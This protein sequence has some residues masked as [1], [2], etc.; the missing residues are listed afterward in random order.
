LQEA[1]EP[2]DFREIWPRVFPVGSCPPELMRALV[3]DIVDGDERFIWE[4]SVH[5][6]LAEWRAAD[7]D[8]ADVAF[9]VVD[10]ETTGSTP[11]FGKITEIGAVRVQNGVV[12][13][14]FSQLVDPL[15]PIPRIITG[16][17]GISDR[18]VAGKPTID[19]V[20]PRFVEFSRDSVMVAHNARFDMGFLDYELGMLCRQSFQRPVLD[21]M[22][23]ARR[24][25]PQLRS[26]LAA[27]SERFATAARPS[28]RALDAA[29]PT[30]ELLLIFLARLQEDG[31]ST[32]EDIVRFCQPESRRNYHKIVL[33]ERLPS[34]PGVYIM[35]D[36]NEAP[37]YVGKAESLRRRTRDHFL[38]KQAYGARQALE[39]LHH[40]DVIETGS[41]FEALLLET[42]LIG[43]LGPPYNDR[44][45]HASG[46]QYVKLSDE[47]FPRLYVTPNRLDDGGF[48]AGP[49]RSQSFARR[50]VECLTSAYPLRTCARMPRTTTGVAH[51][52]EG[53]GRDAEP[54]DRA[55][56]P[57]PHGSNGR[58]A[59]RGKRVGRADGTHGCARYDMGACLA[60]CRH[61]LDGSYTRVVEQVRRVLEGDGAELEGMLEARLQE[62]VAALAF[63]KAAKLQEQRETLT[64]A[65]RLVRRLHAALRT[66][67]VL[68][69][70]AR[71][72]GV[73]RVWGLAGGAV[74][75]EE[76]VVVAQ[77]DREAAAALLSRLY[78][79]PAP[80][81]PLP[82]DTIDEILLIESWLR[83]HR[84]A[85]GVLRLPAPEAGPAGA[86]G[87]RPPLEVAEA[88]ARR[89]ALG[90]SV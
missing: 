11:G 67:G 37:L 71:E 54:E 6:G 69:Y 61:E 48:Y 85:A 28:H 88:L 17:T 41:E 45:T 78:A 79:G 38:Q 16:L 44:G 52:G 39:L 27:L 23:M 81:P 30:A 89:V 4:S 32:L 83:R 19:Q 14:R 68:V 73:A 62:L 58:R 49:F 75:F 65:V 36:E 2:L 56:G 9:T 51:E 22:R 21:T 59:G 13:D 66:W 24:L 26:S 3:A 76:D 1:G 77:F 87:A 43:E 72:P 84:E 8:L 33:T 31:L 70:P 47:A 15:M 90:V 74:A 80:R 55:G 25:W 29:A 35:R 20:L 50:L 42:R 86:V 5:I 18:M 10:L 82:V 64:Q 53:D 40:I 60:P 34:G 46:Y 12:V 57:E 7:R 63:E